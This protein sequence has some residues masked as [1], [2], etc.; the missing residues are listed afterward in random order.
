M[1][2]SRLTALKGLVCLA[3]LLISNAPLAYAQLS[4]AGTVWDW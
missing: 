2:A 1:I 3:L 4:S